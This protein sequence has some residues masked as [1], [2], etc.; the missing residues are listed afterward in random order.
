MT[1]KTLLVGLDAA[2]WSY[3]HPL[4]EAG[5][6]PA[7]HR[8]MASGVWGTLDSTIPALTPAAWTSIVTG[9]LPGKHG[10]F[11]MYSLRPGSYDLIPTHSKL[12]RGTPFWD[13]L[14]ECGLRVGLVNLPFTHPPGA[15]NGFA[16]TGFGAP[17]SAD[18]LTYPP[19]ILAWI[20]DRFGEYQPWL[21]FERLGNITPMAKVLADSELQRRNVQIALELAEQFEVEILVINLM[22]IDHANHLLPT[23][24]QV[25]E[26]IRMTD[27]DMDQLIQSFEP[28]NVMVISDHGSRRVKGDFLLHAWLR[29]HGYCIQNWRGPS[30]RSSALNWILTRW[31][32]EKRIASGRLEKL[33][34]RLLV[35][36][37][38]HLPSGLSNALWRTIE[39]EIPFAR[40]HVLLDG[41]LDHAKSQV[42]VGTSGS[43][44][45]YLN[46]ADRDPSGFVSEDAKGRLIDGLVEKLSGIMDPDTGRPLFAEIYESSELFGNNTA[47]RVPDLVL[48]FYDAEWNIS[49]SFHRGAIAQVVRDRYFAENREEFG[50]HSRE[51]IFVFSGRD[52]RAGAN[53]YRGRVADVPATLLHLYNV[54]IPSDFDGRVLSELIAPD[55]TEAHPLRFQSGDGV[56]N[57]SIASGYSHE[58]SEEIANHLRMLGYI[59]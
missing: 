36:L 25:Q 9:K 14:N 23:L 6:L 2:C 48:D 30:D 40:E 44:L 56:D 28:E 5:E 55:F 26:A 43:G 38:P 27:S 7:L 11:D 53:S 29:D 18:D 46:L 37:I 58:E 22:L 34:R 16:V 10:I 24:E 50:H 33:V 3:L 20:K 21:R 45:L 31:F 47:V 39:K 4:L 54:P 41:K 42:F 15:I 32:R 59:D 57:E 51:G 13:Y 49:M 12:R 19:E 8:L 35:A 52:F 17:S 1:K